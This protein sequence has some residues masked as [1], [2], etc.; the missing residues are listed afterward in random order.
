MLTLH[1]L[2]AIWFKAVAFSSKIPLPLFATDLLSCTIYLLFVFFLKVEF[3]TPC[4]HAT[5]NC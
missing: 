5:W 4:L 1:N 2:D 3:L